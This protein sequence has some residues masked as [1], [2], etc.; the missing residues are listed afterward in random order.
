MTEA[1][2]NPEVTAASAIWAV[3]QVAGELRET[4]LAVAAATVLLERVGAGCAHP[5]IKLARRSGED[6]LD[7]AGDAESQISDGVRRLR[8]AA[9]HR[10]TVT[11]GGLVEALDGVRSRL[12]ATADRIG[13]LPDRVTVA[14]RQLLDAAPDDH[15]AAADAVR[16]WRRAAEQLALMAES[17]TA[18]VDALSTYTCGL[19]GMGG[20][21]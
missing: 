6:A 13:R 12:G 4:Y 10:E 18:A 16:Q 2:T 17:L 11:V 1:E 7:L 14:G 19:S 15:P 9:D 8:V 21:R 20:P 5:A 3:E